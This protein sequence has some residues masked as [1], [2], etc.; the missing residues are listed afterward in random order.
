MNERQIDGEWAVVG[1]GAALAVAAWWIHSLLLACVGTLGALTALALWVWQRECLSGVSYRRTLSE[2]RAT[3]GDEVHLDIE[4][5]NDKLLPL[6]WLHIE[7]LVPPALTIQG[8]TVLAGSFGNTATLHQ[9]FPM[10]PYQRTRHRLTVVC[11]RRGLHRF[12]PGR[13][14]SGNPLGYRPALQEI[15]HAEQL[16]V[17]PK[18]FPLIWTG[19]A[20]RVP[21][22]DQRA[23]LRLVGD[24]SRMIGVREYQPGDPLRHVDW[25]ATAPGHRGHRRGTAGARRRRGPRR[26]RA[27]PCG[28]RLDPART[29]RGRRGGRGGVAAPAAP[30]DAPTP[31]LGGPR[32]TDP[33]LR[34]QLGGEVRPAPP[35]PPLMVAGLMVATE[36]SADGAGCGT[37]AP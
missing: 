37:A 27:P 7:D 28:G 34:L 17:Y 8:G 13:M 24:P 35:S 1:L 32:R 12:G 22:G 30:P 5:V 33:R 15:R 4:V 2:H 31:T 3:F 16:L 6:T 20:S 11:D 9:L 23:Q 10:L 19:P 14:E 21:L 25:R 29:G 26:R 18:V 36:P